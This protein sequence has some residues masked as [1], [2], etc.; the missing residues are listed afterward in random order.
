MKNLIITLVFVFTGFYAFGQTTDAERQI[1]W[2]DVEVIYNLSENECAGTGEEISNS[3]Q[4]SLNFGTQKKAIQKSLTEL[5]K[6]AAAKGYK[7]I[8]VDESKTK[9]KRFNKRGIEVSLVG[10]GL[11]A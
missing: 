2:Q 4:T 6:K 7:T 9:V 11:C 1:A 3:L 10:Y 5:K 8:Y